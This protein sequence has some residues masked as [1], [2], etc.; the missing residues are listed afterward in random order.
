ADV[1]HRTTL[2]T[3]LSSIFAAGSLRVAA[4]EDGIPVWV[5]PVLI[6]ML[7]FL[8]WWW[9]R[10]PAEEVSTSVQAERPENP[11]QQ[12]LSVIAQEPSAPARSGSLAHK[13]SRGPTP[14][15]GSAESSAPP[16]MEDS[17]EEK[18]PEVPPIDVKPD[19]LTIVEGIGPKINKVLHAAG[20]QSL[21]QL[22]DSE[23]THLK[24]ILNGAGIKL[25]DPTTWPEQAGLAAA[26]DQETLKALQATLKGGR[27]V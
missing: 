2:L 9:L 18:M 4:E 11:L 6:L 21:S 5:W 14:Q 15:P 19:D 1:M 23:V 20:I 13:V 25:A 12:V 26:G 17:Q 16:E 7:G 24:K 27:K 3:V 22:S 8:V 10:K